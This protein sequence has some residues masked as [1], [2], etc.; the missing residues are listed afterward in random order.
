MK[1]NRNRAGRKTSLHN[2]AMQTRIQKGGGNPVSSNDVVLDP[3]LEKVAGQLCADDCRRL[4]IIYETW[5]DD[6]VL[7]ASLIDGHECRRNHSGQ[8]RTGDPEL[9]GMIG[10]DSFEDGIPLTPDACADMAATLERWTILLRA[11][12]CPRSRA[13]FAPRSIRWSER[14]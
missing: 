9:D 7:K 5:A 13:G 10:G 8:V 1:R 4:A 11:A 14:N 12:I 3:I 2:A 6:L